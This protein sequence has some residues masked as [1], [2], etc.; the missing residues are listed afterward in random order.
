[1]F[2]L[3]FSLFVGVAIVVATL[4]LDLVLAKLGALDSVNQ[5]I[6]DISPVADGGRP[7]APELTT[8]RIVGGAVL[9]A[10]V[11]VVLLTA[12]ATVSAFL[13]NLCASFT[14]GIEV[15]LGEQD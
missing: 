12:L 9:I 1:M 6:S 11:D 4:V 14:G 10:A 3:V 7:R 8:G 13:Y 15:T 5:L 2:S